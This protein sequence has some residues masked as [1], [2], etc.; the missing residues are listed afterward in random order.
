MG[1]WD[2]L[3]TTADTTNQERQRQ[4][5]QA[6]GQAGGFAN[7]GQSAFGS[8]GQALA[9]QQQQ[10]ADQAAGKN[11]VSGELLRQGM[12]QGQAAQQSM[13][14]SASPQNAAM[15]AQNA[16][17]NMNRLGY[18]LSGQQAVAGLQEANQARQ[19]LAQML[20]Q[21]RQQELQAALQAR[22]QQMGAYQTQAPQSAATQMIGGGIG[23]LAAAVPGAIAASDRR[24]KRDV[25]SG[26]KDADKALK[27]L[28][29]FA[30]DYKDDRHGKGRQFGV[31]AQD[32]ERAG[33][34]HAV[35]DTPAGKMVHGARAAT[36]A[37]ALTAA[38][39]KR[40]SK[41]EGGK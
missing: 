10:L 7:Q 11:L 28:R 26:D 8:L 36:S 14:A 21:Q 24:L 31:M 4:L 9:S 22:G 3:Q 12:Q 38:L 16:M 33:L 34:G 37:L 40:V 2:F 13:A 25:D 23:G 15:A 39:A 30:F 27:H 20:L 19:A 5:D 29:A 32:M 41:L 6:A 18:G 35:I 1:F 17:N